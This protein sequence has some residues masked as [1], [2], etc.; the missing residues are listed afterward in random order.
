LHIKASYWHSS[1]LDLLQR[2]GKVQEC[3]IGSTF[4]VIS[5][6][7]T[8]I[9][10]HALPHKAARQAQPR[11][12]HES[13]AAWVHKNK[14]SGTEIEDHIEANKGW[15][16]Q[17]IKRNLQLQV[18]DFWKQELGCSLNVLSKMFLLI[19]IK[20]LRQILDKFLNLCKKLLLVK[21]R[22]L[23]KAS[24]KLF[25]SFCPNNISTQRKN[26]KQKK[27]WA[28]QQI[29]HKLTWS[30]NVST[31]ST[32]LAAWSSTPSSSSPPS[33]EGF[34]PMSTSTAPWTT[35]YTQII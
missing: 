24:T 21:W 12:Y 20:F 11:K 32:T 18:L 13:H 3:W 29:A 15:E 25:I 9:I 7:Q 27:A 28:I 22:L 6:D 23:L 30:L 1:A 14:L 5:K 17:S 33:A 35:H 19:L 4:F 16:H 31:M 2:R 8:T 34:A 10:M 26:K